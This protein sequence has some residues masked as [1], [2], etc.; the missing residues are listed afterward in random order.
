MN[1]K[2]IIIG[3]SGGVDSAV[4]MKLLKDQEYNV[5]AIFMKNWDEDD[6]IDVCTV[7]EDLVYVEDACNK[8]S[9]KL[10]TVNFSDEYWNNIFLDFL[11]KYKKGHT[12]N[13]D[14]LCNKYIKFKVFIEYAEKLGANKV[15]T[16]HYAKIVENNGTFFLER[17]K[18]KKKD[19]TYFLH[20]LDQNQLS[21]IIFPLSNF[22]KSEVKKIAKSC[23]FASY[24]RKE[25]MGICFIGN[26]KFKKFISNYINNM[27]GD[28]LDDNEN[29]LGT[30]KGIFYTT[31]GQRE[32]IGI[33][34]IKNKKNLPWYVYKKDLV[35]NKLYICQG[36]NNKL[37]LH[38]KLKINDMHVIQGDTNTILN[39]RLECQIRHL[40]EKH[41]C[42]INKTTDN[43][44]FVESFLPFKSPASGQSLVIYENEKCL[45]GG[46]ITNV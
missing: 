40:G 32:G 37:L 25:S 21:K 34:G 24:N 18:D 20:T 19:Q 17:P 23:N 8:L 12:P 4:S 7:K 35:N 2:K 39:K 10:H 38:N 15:A 42:F 30:H 29:I 28:I 26:K 1:N 43:S 5:E 11:E 27:P 31:I 33:G 46:I 44:F 22:Y 45:G 6:T 3:V 36:N 16:G 41:Q 14:I 13:P 9:I